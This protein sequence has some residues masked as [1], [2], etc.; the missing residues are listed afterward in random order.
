MHLPYV[1]IVP[2]VSE[3][4]RDEIMHKQKALILKSLLNRLRQKLQWCMCNGKHY[5]SILVVHSGTNKHLEDQNEQ[6]G[7]S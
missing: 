5:Q 4:M 3:A 6:L 7:L 1:Q 2:L